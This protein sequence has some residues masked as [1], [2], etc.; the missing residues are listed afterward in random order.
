MTAAQRLADGIAG[1]A[2]APVREL[3]AAVGTLPPTAVP[4]DRDAYVARVDRSASPSPTAPGDARRRDRGRVTATGGAAYEVIRTRR[5]TR[6]MSTEPVGPGAV[7]AGAASAR[8][9]PNAGNRR[10]QP[11]VPVTDPGWSGCCG[12]SP[13]A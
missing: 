3:I 12:W 13:R 11:V 1:R 6:N 2:S 8:Y 4:S 10:L 7:R 5:V 9:A